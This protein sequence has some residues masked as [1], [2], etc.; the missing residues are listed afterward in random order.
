MSLIPKIIIPHFH[1]T[2][3]QE[4][5]RHQKKKKQKEEN[6]FGEHGSMGSTAHYILLVK[7][8]IERYRLS[9]PLH[10]VSHTLLEPSTPKLHL[11]VIL[12]G[13]VGVVHG[14][15]DTP[16]LQLGLG[17][18]LDPMGKTDRRCSGL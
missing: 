6:L 17:L 16:D 3:S 10:R 14:F 5:N 11:L 13:G 12:C 18:G 2:F 9:E 7:L 15:Q 8:L 4:T 1:K